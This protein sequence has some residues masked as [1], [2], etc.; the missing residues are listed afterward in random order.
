M[1]TRRAFEVLRWEGIARFLNRALW[2]IVHPVLRVERVR[3]FESDLS[4]PLPPMP[5]RASPDLRVGS[6]ADLS[7]FADGFA[8]LGVEIEDVRERLGRGDVFFLAVVRGEMASLS[9]VTRNPTW[10]DEAAVWL[11]LGPDEASVYG[12]TTLPAW[13]G[14]G[15]A[16]ALWRYVEQWAR[17]QGFVRLITWVR[18]DNVQ[19]VKTT[20]RLGRR[21]TRMVWKIWAFGMTRPHVLG[22]G[23]GDVSPVLSRTPPAGRDPERPLSRPPRSQHTLAR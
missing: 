23:R 6:L 3:F 2:K 8:R 17:A 21:P 4:R 12:G 5:T 10:V 1:G 9:W 16:P 13:R 20:L 7:T 18:P 15:L 19:S 22:V 11:Q 14:F